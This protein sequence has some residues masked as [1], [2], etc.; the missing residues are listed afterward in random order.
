LNTFLLT[1]P[2]DESFQAYLQYISWFLDEMNE[3]LAV[4]KYNN[5]PSVFEPRYHVTQKYC[6]ESVKFSRCSH[7]WILWDF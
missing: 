3:V 2:P 7:A 6:L 1:F 5:R 4:R